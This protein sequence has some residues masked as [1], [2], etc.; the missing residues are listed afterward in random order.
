MYHLIKSWNKPIFVSLFIVVLF[1][2]FPMMSVADD[3]VSVLDDADSL[4]DWT[5]DNTLTLDTT[6]KTEGNASIQSSGNLP[7]FYKKIFSSPVDTGVTV[8]NGR[9]EFDLYVSDVSQFTTDAGQVE[10]NS[11]TTFNQDELNWSITELG[12]GDGWNHIELDFD[13]ASQIGSP[14]LSAIER[15]SINRPVTSSITMKVDNLVV[16]EK[17]TTLDNA[18]SL[19]GWTSQNTLTLDT[20]DKQEGQ[21]SI[22]SSGSDDR[23]FTNDFS[24]PVDTGV[25]VESGQLEF[26]LYVSDVSQFTTAKGQVELN[27]S[28]TFNQD[29]LYWYIS[30]LDLQNGWNHVKLRLDRANMIGNPDLDAIERFSIYRP[31]TSS[32]TMKIDNLVV[33]EKYTTLDNGDALNGWTSQNTLTLDTTDKQEGQASIQASGSNDR[34]FTKDLSI[35]VDTGVAIESGRLEFDLYVSDV[36]QFTTANGQIELNSATTFNQDEFYWYISDISL[37]NGW[38]HVELDMDQANIIGNPDLNAIQRFSIN[39]PVTSSITMKIDNL[40]VTDPVYQMRKQFFTGPILD[41][42]DLD[43]LDPKNMSDDSQIGVVAQFQYLEFKPGHEHRRPEK[44]LPYAEAAGIKWLRTGYGYRWVAD[45]MPHQTFTAPDYM[46]KWV[47]MEAGLGIRPSFTLT[48]GPDYMPEFSN[49]MTTYTNEFNA[50][51]QFLINRYGDKIGAMEILNEPFH[52]WTEIF[53]GDRFGGG[54]W[55]NEYADFV[56]SAA[57][58]IK[59]ANPNIQVVNGMSDYSPTIEQLRYQ[60]TTPIDV[61]NNHHYPQ[62]LAPDYTPFGNDPNNGEFV[63]SDLE[64]DRVIPDYI[65]QTEKV[66]ERDLDMWM[67]ETGVHTKLVSEVHQAK[68]ALRALTV[69]FLSGADKMFYF[70]LLEGSDQ[71]LKVSHYGLLTTDYQPNPVYFALGRLNALTG[72]MA[73][74]DPDFQATINNLNSE[75]PL[76]SDEV[77]KAGRTFKLNEEIRMEKLNLKNGNSLLAVWSTAHSTADDIADRQIEFAVNDILG[78]RPILVDPLTGNSSVLST[79]TDS[80]DVLFTLDVKDYP[81]FILVHE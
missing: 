2:M 79:Q 48:T 31:V 45:D 6:D 3:V 4:N 14:D 46:D 64:L 47:N 49:D 53:G 22:Q 57:S 68:D 66:A 77:L 60:P 52:D 12:L 62:T 1:V 16:T 75:R 80:G 61:V 40:K 67:T 9:L 17:Y 10:L 54:A 21:A 55:V 76:W 34:F 41:H 35:P 51:S 5:S 71:T 43:S 13:Q 69:G 7:R 25:T 37:A 50:Y 56:M 19:N 26:D 15:F 11:S 8:A 65:M 18:D 38:N 44:V 30:Y 63:S 27:S 42:I 74:P 29:E 32:I 39:R 70:K 72:G 36:S 20:T 58:A 73:T 24:V 81:Q 28:N 23:F 78:D 33:T 59:Q